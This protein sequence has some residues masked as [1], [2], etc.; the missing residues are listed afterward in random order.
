MFRNRIDL[1]LR[2]QLCST[3]DWGCVSV[4]YSMMP[5]VLGRICPKAVFPVRLITL[6]SFSVWRGG[7]HSILAKRRNPEYSEKCDFFYPCWW[8]TGSCLWRRSTGGR[9]MRTGRPISVFCLDIPGQ[10]RKE[11]IYFWWRS[12]LIQAT[13]ALSN[14]IM[15]FNFNFHRVES[16]SSVSIVIELIKCRTLIAPAKLN[17]LET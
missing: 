4:A 3:G 2:A 9:R 6:R 15:I 13:Q 8:W 17:H 10:C 11:N 1:R 5:L 7:T 16:R 14:C 12:S